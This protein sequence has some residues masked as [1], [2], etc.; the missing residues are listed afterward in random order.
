MPPSRFFGLRA[1]SGDAGLPQQGM[2]CGKI[3][4]VLRLRCMVQRQTFL[5]DIGGITFELMPCRSR[6][7]QQ[8]FWGEF[9]LFHNHKLIRQCEDHLS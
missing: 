2:L 1:V 3:S 5:M 7:D 4:K 9:D 6:S 8:R